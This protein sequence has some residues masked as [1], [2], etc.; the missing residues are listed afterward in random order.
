[1]EKKSIE[2]VVFFPEASPPKGSI[3]PRRHDLPSYPFTVI[4]Y[5]GTEKKLMET[6]QCVLDSIGDIV[7]QISSHGF[8]VYIQQDNGFISMVSYQI[9]KMESDNYSIS[10]QKVRTYDDGGELCGSFFKQFCEKIDLTEE[11]T[12]ELPP[13]VDVGAAF[14]PEIVCSLVAAKTSD[15]YCYSI[16]EKEHSDMLTFYKN[17]IQ[18]VYW[19]HQRYGLT[20]LPRLSV[21]TESIMNVL[22]YLEKKTHD[23]EMVLLAI[24]CLQKLSEKNHS[25]FSDEIIQTKMPQILKGVLESAKISSYPFFFHHG[26][27]EKKEAEKMAGSD[28]PGGFI[29]YTDTEDSLT[30][31]MVYRSWSMGTKQFDSYEISI[32]ED[33]QTISYKGQTYPDIWYMFNML[34]LWQPIY[35]HSPVNLLIHK[36]IRKVSIKQM[37]L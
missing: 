31:I 22:D 11:I 8:H 32:N 16:E 4:H 33:D 17:S 14:A 29:I 9:Y 5:Q 27:L 7:C 35:A 37:I 21:D 3:F 28:M 30:K 26:V 15:R 24:I 6:I 23:S 18:S 20:N 10:T 19:E 34:S 1:M 13:D 2:E 36:Q 25:A 12:R